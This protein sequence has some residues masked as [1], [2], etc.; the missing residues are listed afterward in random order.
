MPLISKAC[1]SLSGEIIV[2]GDKSI[3]HRAL[4]LGALAIGETN[5]NG[6]LESQDIMATVNALRELGVQV[7]KTRSKKWQ[8]LGVGTNGFKEPT[9]VLDLGNSGTAVRL[10]MGAVSSHQLTTFFS[11][12]HSL[13]TRPMGRVVE[14]LTLMGAKMIS[15]NSWRLPLALTGSSNL[16][17]IDYELPVPSAQ[18]KSAILLAGLSAPGETSVVENIPSRNHT[19]NMLRHFG[20]SL[21]IQDN[22]DG[23]RRTTL[24]GYKE[25]KG[26][27]VSV[28]ADISSAAFLI[29]AALLVPQSNLLLRN[30]GINPLR[31]GLLTC[32]GEMGGRIRFKNKRIIAKENIADILVE[33]S[34]LNC[35]DVPET[36]APT[37]IDEYPILAML[38]ACAKG[39]SRLRGLRELRFKESDRFVSLLKGLNS[40][41]V[42]I[43]EEGEDLMIEGLGRGPVGGTKINCNYDHRISMSFLVLGMIAKNGIIIDD[44]GMIDTSFPKFIDLINTLGG[45]IGE[46]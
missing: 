3:S 42:H 35:I 18:V 28:P 37:M 16:L 45:N 12:D 29:S 38:A 32:I 8:I 31:S 10:L 14:P 44:G 43:S 9:Q 4:I 23:T 46:A 27:E 15:R 21:D 2:P 39:K 17:P 41:G 7:E 22:S 20:A 6:L 30:I 19:E 33:S 1:K 34:D 36:R 11:G 13:N 26:A 25:L 40:C 5:V 24:R